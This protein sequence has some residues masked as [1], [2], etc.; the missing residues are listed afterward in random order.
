M[1]R[2]IQKHPLQKL[3]SPTRG[4]SAIIHVRSYTPYV[5]VG[6]DCCVG[7]QGTSDA[8]LVKLRRF[9][10]H[11]G[12]PLLQLVWEMMLTIV[13]LT[14]HPRNY[15]CLPLTLPAWGQ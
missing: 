1:E 5:P 3:A 10:Q 9:L 13:Q 15:V 7:S 12:Y 6:H 4:L 2:L 11:V 14:L 8:R